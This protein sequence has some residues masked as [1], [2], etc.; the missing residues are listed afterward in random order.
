MTTRPRLGAAILFFA[1]AIA[2]VEHPA[3]AQ[4]Y[5]T[6]TVRITVSAGAGSLPDLLGRMIADGLSAKYGKAFIVE[7]KPGAT[8]IIA[9]EAVKNAK[10]D[11]H[12][13]LLADNAVTA[14]NK[15]MHA[16]L[17]YD[18]E[19]DFTPI[20]ELARQP[21]LVFAQVGLGVKS[22]KELVTLLKA[23]PGELNYGSAGL[24][25]LQHLCAERL[26]QAVGANATH[27]PYKTGN[28][29][30]RGVIANE[31]QFGCSGT[32]AFQMV[33]TGK[34]N[35]LIV[36]SAE[37]TPLSPNAPTLKQETGLEGFEMV[38]RI[39]ILAPVGTP[40]N[41]VEQLSIDMREVFKEQR[42][43]DLLARQ[44]A[45]VAVD[46]PDAYAAVIRREIADFANV[47]KAAGLTPQ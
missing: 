36:T 45:E 33:E 41:I 16:K 27:I 20:T 28:D 17:P 23:K 42:L 22:I 12:T 2:V 5:P 14:I 39:G 18:P 32:S 37:R 15:S 8:G 46:G 38:A 24:G 21:F 11:G 9:A 29:L 43:R 31:V 4:S 44:N 40:R 7:N 34:A 3:S 26:L 35:L 1:A 47:V 10:P 19:K 25:S 13:L 30:S 6:Q